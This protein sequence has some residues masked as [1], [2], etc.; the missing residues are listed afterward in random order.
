MKNLTKILLINA[1]ASDFVEVLKSCDANVFYMTTNQAIDNDISSFYGY[2]VFADYKSIDPRLRVKL[3][4][5]AT[6]GKRI[7]LEAV[8][9]WGGI[10]CAPPTATVRSRL[11]VASD[12]ISGL[13]KGDLLDEEGN[14]S[15]RPWYVLPETMRPILV[16][17]EQI[18]AHDRLKDDQMEEMIKGGSSGLWTMDENVM[19]SSFVLH[20]FNR[21]RFAPR[22]SWQHVIAFIAEWLTKSPPS[23]M[24]ES[25]V[26]HRTEYDLADDA[27]FEKERKETVS[28]GIEWLKRFLV[29]EGNG[30]I[31]E[32]LKHNIN[33]EGVQEIAGSVRTDCVG[34]AAGA[35][36][37]FGSLY[38]NGDALTISERLESF[39]FGPMQIKGGLFD[40]MIRWTDSAWE[41]CYQDDVA[42]AVLP[43]LYAC[44]F[45]GRKEYLSGVYAALDFLVKTTAKD[46]CRVCR[47]DGPHLNAEKIKELSEAEHG[48]PSAHYNAYYHAALLMAYKCSQN[49][50][51][52][53]VAQKGIERLMSIY[54]NTR[55]EQSETEEMCRLILPLSLLYSVTNHEKHR[56][57]LYRVTH[58]LVSHRHKSGGYP[59]WDTGYAATCSRE[60]TGECSLLTENGDPIADLLYSSNWLPIGFAMAYDATGDKMFYDLWRG[61]AAFFIKTQVLSQTDILNGSWCRAFDMERNEVYGCPHDVGWAANCSESGW[62]VAEILMGLMLPDI[63]SNQK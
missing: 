16:Y 56:E 43:T 50:V 37:F 2:C 54:P 29:D 24:P 33:S 14:F 58:D 1:T 4:A 26:R 45:L 36:R 25:V 3:E 22:K 19:I 53:E 9:S 12:C 21:A 27:V 6:N 31:R 28:L 44:L 55:R 5:E 57:M 40:G 13:A 32:G 23:Y 17:R 39:V 38:H 59:E 7:F 10:Y 18:I 42:R 63:L 61:I 48:I 20:N 30:G 11:I 52:F 62:T 35:F 46:G 15:M 51:Y 60:S 49:E 47:T 8:E 41:V 34:E